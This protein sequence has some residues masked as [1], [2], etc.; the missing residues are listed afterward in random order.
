MTSARSYLTPYPCNHRSLS[1]YPCSFMPP[2]SFHLYH[3][4][5]VTSI[6]KYLYI[7]IYVPVQTTYIKL[8]GE[9][10]CTDT[11]VQ[12]W[13]TSYLSVV[14]GERVRVPENGLPGMVSVQG[15]LHGCN[16]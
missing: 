4:T 12:T 1:P 11:P 9:S 16:G 13:L 8:L 5:G 6:I 15:P 3:Y 7:Y 10:F 14:C 2:K